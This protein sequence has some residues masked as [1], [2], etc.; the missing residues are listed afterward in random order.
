MNNYLDIPEE[1]RNKILNTI[2]STPKGKTWSRLTK[3]DK[4]EPEEIFIPLDISER[5]RMPFDP[6]YIMTA[7]HGMF[8]ITARY[9]YCLKTKKRGILDT[10]D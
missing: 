6:A 10:K 2:V 7:G 9:A 8:R 5:I 4:P 3:I 1:A